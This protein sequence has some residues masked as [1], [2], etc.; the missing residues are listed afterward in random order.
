MKE[1]Y[2]NTITILKE[3][4]NSLNECLKKSDNNIH[5]KNGNNRFYNRH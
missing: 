2:L 4:K 5:K 3:L 1:E